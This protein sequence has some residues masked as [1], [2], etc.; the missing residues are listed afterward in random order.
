VSAAEVLSRGPLAFTPAHDLNAVE[1]ADMLASPFA[2][3]AE[4]VVHHPMPLFHTEHCL[5]AAHLSEGHGHDTCGRPCDRHRLALC[6]RTGREHP[7]V[8]DVGCRNT[9]LHGAPQSAADLV[10]RL[11]DLGVRR[12]R[13]E[14]LSEGSALSAKIVRKY[15]AL[16]QGALSPGGFTLEEPGYD[17]VRGSLRVLS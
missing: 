13:V 8:A 6:D 14:L 11:R 17:L 16:V 5:F 2:P 9:V 12:W 7:V 3:F 4:V 1:L 15:L 10:V